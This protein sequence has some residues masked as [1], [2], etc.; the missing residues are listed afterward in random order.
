GAIIHTINPRLFHDQLVYIVNDAED[1]VVFFDLT[2]TPLVEKLAP[3]CPGVKHWVALTDR[4]HLPQSALPGLSCYEDLLAAESDDFEW[5]EFDENTASG[6]CYTAGTTGRPH[7]VDEPAQ[8]HD[9]E[10]AALF[11]T[12]I[13]DHRWSGLSAGDDEDAFGTVR[14][15]R[16][17][18]LGHDRDEP[19]RHGKCAQGLSPGI[20]RRGQIPAR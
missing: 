14:R 7:R 5:P 19:G 4:A 2:F 13:V 1:R 10:Q 6:L 11:D 17:P 9:P 15:T 12:E 20:I 3:L 8:L 16:P 18:R